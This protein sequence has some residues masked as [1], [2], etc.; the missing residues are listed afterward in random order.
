[1]RNEV[2]FP[3]NCGGLRSRGYRDGR[4]ESNKED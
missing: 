2:I 3:Q 4:N 1:M